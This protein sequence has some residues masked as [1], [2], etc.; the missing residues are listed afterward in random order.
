MRRVAMKPECFDKALCGNKQWWGRPHLMASL[1]AVCGLHRH[2]R[3]RR[4]AKSGT[5][6]DFNGSFG[7]IEREVGAAQHHGM[8]GIG[9][10]HSP[11]D[12]I[13]DTHRLVC[14]KTSA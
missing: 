12:E 2:R 8:A 13:W 14:K 3:N 7:N 11:G 6:T 4:V 5:P 9:A 10:G 1:E